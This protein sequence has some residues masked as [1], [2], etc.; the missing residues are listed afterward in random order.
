M[1]N[2]DYDRALAFTLT[3]EGGYSNQP[4]DNGGATMRGITQAVFWAYLSGKGH[5]LRPVSTLTLAELQDIYY[6]QYW[7][8]AAQ[9]RPWPINAMCFDIAV[10]HGKANAVWML[11]EAKK[12]VSVNDPEWK[13]KLAL[14]MCD[15]RKQFYLDIIRRNP[16]QV[17]FYRGWMRRCDGARQLAKQP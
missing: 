3:Y 9:N 11:A 6:N 4:A 1:P 15:V 14:A 7:L 17:V 10:N 2:T 5:A 12:N 13:L 8:P 16:A